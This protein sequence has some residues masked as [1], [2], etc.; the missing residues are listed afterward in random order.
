[1]APTAAA[2]TTA[3]DQRSPGEPA[4][5]CRADGAVRGREPDRQ[6]DAE[7]HHRLQ[8]QQHAQRE[9][10]VRAIRRDQVVLGE[11][12]LGEGPADDPRRG[13]A[14]CQQRDRA[15]QPQRHEREPEREPDA[16]R[17]QRAARVGEHQADEQEAERG[18]GERAARGVAG[19]P[20][21]QPQQGRH[22]ERCHQPDG[23][24]VAERRA[25]AGDELVLG[26]PLRETPWSAALQRR[27]PR[28]PV[29][30]PA[31]TAPP[32]P[33]ARRARRQRSGERGQVGEDAIG[34][35]P[36][37]RGVDRPSDRQRGE[38]RERG[39]A[40]RASPC[41]RAA[42]A[43][44]AGAGTAS[45][46]AAS[47]DPATT[48]STSANVFCASVTPPSA[49]NASAQSAAATARVTARSAA[50]TSGR[51]RAAAAGRQGRRRRC[52]S[53][54]SAITS[55][56][57]SEFPG[58]PSRK[59]ETPASTVSSPIVTGCWATLERRVDRLHGRRR[60]P[61]RWAGWAWACRLA[62]RTRPAP[63]DGLPAP[64]RPSPNS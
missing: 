49:K 59:G 32:R 6:P 53:R 55:A 21:S 62:G 5:A 3:V 4:C 28:R 44:H 25:Q 34:L 15:A 36:R 45:A 22:A 39:E 50:L 35:E 43:P 33:G 27:S 56:V 11:R 38:D 16:E 40:R 30:H 19:A 48:S 61:A 64:I 57:G 37:V 17:E 63:V 20:R 47:P 52:A 14:G 8:Q 42:A 41:R 24:P 13:Q 1:M 58:R 2:M 10:R 60:S 29:R 26:E 46:A 9:A 12:L 7:Q 51:A 31:S 18:I 23:V 54:T